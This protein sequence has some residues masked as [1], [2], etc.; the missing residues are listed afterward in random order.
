MTEDVVH[1]L[2]LGAIA[3][4]LNSPTRGVAVDLLRRA[5]KVETE[6][7]QIS[8]AHGRGVVYGNHQA[9]A[10]GDPFASD[11]GTLSASITHDLATD[12]KGL[13]ARIGSNDQRMGWLE[14]GTS[15]IEP[16]P[17]LRPALKAAGR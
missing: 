3:E 6:A 7:K 2:N 5:V 17:T 12:T 10:P 11:T 1:V 16:R 8:H 9:S 14:Y 15:R 13:L 4:L